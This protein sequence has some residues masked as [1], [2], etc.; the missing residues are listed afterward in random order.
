MTA[1]LTILVVAA[2]AVLAG[3]V[4]YLWL[5]LAQATRREGLQALAARRGW[6]LNI[7]T[8]YLGR[9]GMLRLSP[10]G[11]PA[12]SVETRALSSLIESASSRA[13]ATEY[14]AGEPHWDEGTLVITPP[15]PATLTPTAGGQA[16]DSDVGRE[17]LAARLGKGF[18][19][20]APGLAAWPAPD[21]IG[22]LCTQDP[23]PRFDP[24]AIARAIDTLWPRR[25]PR[26][27]MVFS[28][29]GLRLHLPE[30]LHRAEQMEKFID[31]AHELARLLTGGV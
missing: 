27:V 14:L 17:W 3:G 31:L 16:L 9:P 12:W 28:P 15:L 2:F 8:E 29:E 11:G 21:G 1:V 19:H 4:V 5:R 30:G 10:R 7:S 24:P 22:L 23:L 25:E 6:A 18:A 20:T 26:P 13:K